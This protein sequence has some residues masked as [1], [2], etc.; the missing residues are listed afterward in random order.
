MRAQG[1]DR[2][3]GSPRAWRSR[4][5]CNWG[6]IRR[7][8]GQGAHCHFRHHQPVSEPLEAAGPCAGGSRHATHPEVFAPSWGTS[9]L[10]ELCLLK[11]VSGEG[12]QEGVRTQRWVR[13]RTLEGGPLL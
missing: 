6:S 1:E 2:L 4:K 3:G 13:G 9:P 10:Q 11:V 5:R 8:H 12:P 7:S